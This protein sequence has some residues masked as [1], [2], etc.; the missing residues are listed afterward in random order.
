M[1]FKDFS[2]SM[3]GAKLTKVSV[4][5]TAGVKLPQDSQWL[6]TDGKGK[7]FAHG[8]TDNQLVTPGPQFGKKVGMISLEGSAE[9]TE[10]KKGKTPK[11]KKSK[12]EL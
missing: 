12:Q 2:A 7:N 6:I 5:D 10:K 11:T 9:K 1:V 3:N 4:E 8:D